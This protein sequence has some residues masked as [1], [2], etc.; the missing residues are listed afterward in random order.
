MAG[1]EGVGTPP[2]VAASPFPAESD[3]EE[4][5]FAG[6][7]AEPCRTTPSASG[8]TFS[9]AGPPFFLKRVLSI[10]AGA[11][12]PPLRRSA[13]SGSPFLAERKRARVARHQKPAARQSVGPQEGPFFFLGMIDSEL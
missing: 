2:L 6:G 10:P 7:S 12:P 1:I 8:D 9:G 13:R 11:L 5:C 3:D 4:T